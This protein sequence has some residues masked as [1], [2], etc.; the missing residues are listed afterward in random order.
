M[1]NRVLT[2]ISLPEGLEVS[3]YGQFGG[4]DAREGV[5]LIGWGMES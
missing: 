3:F 4:Q 1:V 2:Q 5:L